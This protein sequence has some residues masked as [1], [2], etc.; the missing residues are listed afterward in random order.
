MGLRNTSHQSRGQAGF[1]LIEVLVSLTILVVIASLGL[2][3]SIDFYKAYSSRSE[4]SVIVS[5]LQKARSESLNNINEKR[6]GVH[7]QANPL[8]YVIFECDSP[9]TSY[10]VGGASSDQPIESSHNVSVTAPSMPFDVVFDQLNGNCV[11]SNC[12]TNPL[13]VTISDGPKSY[14]LKVNSEGRIDW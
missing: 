5:V 7:F 2:F 8:Q 11:S 12:S 14:T 1:T 3:I 13:T 4:Q 10:P 9:C 6:H